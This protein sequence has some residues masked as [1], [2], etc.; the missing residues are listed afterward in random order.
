[1]IAIQIA[2]FFLLKEDHSEKR[3]PDLQYDSVGDWICFVPDADEGRSAGGKHAAGYGDHDGTLSDLGK[4][5]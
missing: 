1:M 2:D 4:N 5:Q 3:N